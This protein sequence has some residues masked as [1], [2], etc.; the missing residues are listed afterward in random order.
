MVP[1]IIGTA[2]LPSVKLLA[3][4]WLEWE[5]SPKTT[6]EKVDSAFNYANI[7]L[8]FFSIASGLAG[9]FLPHERIR[10]LARKSF[11]LGQGAK[12]GANAAH[13]GIKYKLKQGTWDKKFLIKTIGS[14]IA[15]TGLGLIQCNRWYNNFSLNCARNVTNILPERLLSELQNNNVPVELV[16]SYVQNFFS[17]NAGQILNFARFSENIYQ[18]GQRMYSAH[19][20]LQTYKTSQRR[21]NSNVHTLNDIAQETLQSPRPHTQ[22]ITT[23]PIRTTNSD[24]TPVRILNGQITN[25]NDLQTNAAPIENPVEEVEEL[26]EDSA[27]ALAKLGALFAIQICILNALYINYFKNHYPEFICPITKEPIETIIKEKTTGRFFEKTNIEKR[28]NDNPRGFNF[29]IERPHSNQEQ[30]QV[31]INVFITKES[32]EENVEDQRQ[33]DEIK[34]LVITSI[35]N[36]IRSPSC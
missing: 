30:G 4:A 25:I 33:L 5:N 6:E 3:D 31:A 23:E 8:S 26:I 32:F 13:L 11:F 16:Q 27:E 22:N 9:N 1:V 15:D 12:I 28:L 35:K 14:I 2:I 34:F 21:N 20:R 7:F 29:T 24:T 19:Q 10:N 36:T 18:N 17:E